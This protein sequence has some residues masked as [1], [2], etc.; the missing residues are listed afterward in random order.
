M[1]D[2]TTYSVETGSFKYSPL[3]TPIYQTSAFGLPEGIE[4]RYSREANPTVEDLT[5]FLARLEKVRFCSA[6]SSG[7]GAISSVFL[8]FLRPGDSVL[9]HADVFAR[10]LKFLR[11]F[12]SQWGVKTTVSGTGTEALLSKFSGQKVVFVET[13]SN[14]TL[15]VHDLKRIRDTIGDGPLLITDS[16]FATP[17]NLNPASFGSDVIIH[18]GSKFLSG[19]N[20]V[21]AGFALGNQERMQELE[22]FRKTIGDT[23]D[24]FTAFLVKRGLKTLR[25][26]VTNS[27]ASAS[28]IAESLCS[29]DLIQSIHYPGLMEHPD[30]E[31]AAKQLKGFGS[32]VSFSVRA[33]SIDLADF[34]RNLKLAVP[35]NTLG[36]L[37]STISHPATMSHR[38]FS[39]EEMS[40]AGFDQ[41][42]FR[43]SLGIE[44]WEDILEDVQTALRKASK[45]T[46]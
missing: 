45:S 27:N 2:E 46:A 1:K 7:M 21:I 39:N 13:I 3:V 29:T 23:M 24:P 38:S 44:A 36:G 25:L 18:S 19:H 9:I 43:L 15:R 6:F 37:N 40:A 22:S 10:T 26:R 33:D 30:H 5:A 34:M 28:K 20:D 31:I 16:T 35:A 8:H 17:V 41:N 32:V 14:P 11:D 4:Y 42:L 12:L